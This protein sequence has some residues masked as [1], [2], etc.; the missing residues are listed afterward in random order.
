[1]RYIPKETPVKIGEKVFTSGL[2]GIFPPGLLVGKVLDA[3]P[4]IKDSYL[5]ITIEPAFDLA[6]LTELFIIVDES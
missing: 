1:M 2:D 4:S 3:R 6:Q 5:E